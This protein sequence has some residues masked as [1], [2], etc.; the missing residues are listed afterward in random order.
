MVIT[1]YSGSSAFYISLGYLLHLKFNKKLS[2]NY[3]SFIHAVGAVLL[4]TMY[5]LYQK[6]HIYHSLKLWSSGYFIADSIA[7]IKTGKISIMN[8]AYLYHHTAATYIL[9][10]D[11][12]KYMGPD[13]ILWGELSNLPT[14][15]VYHYLHTK[16]L[17]AK[18]LFFWKIFQKYVYTSIRVPIVSIIA[19]NMWKKAQNKKPIMVIFPVYLMGLIWTAKILQEKKVPRIK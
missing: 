19:I 1:Q 11:P 4:G 16:I 8:I 12:T 10:Q 17:L 14:Y 6:K 2:A 9:H 7:L 5:K 3:V 13:L 15:F 18:Q